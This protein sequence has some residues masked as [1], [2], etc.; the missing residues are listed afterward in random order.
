MLLLIDG[1]NLLHSGRTLVDL[2]AIELQRERERLIEKL[3]LYRQIK[4]LQ[5][6]V[7]FDGWQGG[8]SEERR[9]KK[10]GIEVIFSRVGEKADEVIKR[11]MKERGSGVVVVTS[12]REIARYVNKF[13]IPVIPS[14]QFQEKLDRTSYDFRKEDWQEN[15]EIVERGGKKKG[16]SKQLSKKEKRLMSILQKL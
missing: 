16:P 9:E 13:S 10:R 1:Y 8:W 12:D 7:V 3:S 6:A 15:V 4:S 5:V 14:E 2:S 11:I